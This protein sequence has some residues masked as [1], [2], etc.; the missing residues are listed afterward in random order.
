[1][2]FVKSSHFLFVLIVVFIVLGAAAFFGALKDACAPSALAQD[3]VPGPYVVRSSSATFTLAADASQYVSFPFPTSPRKR[4][5]VG[6]IVA[7]DV[8]PHVVG[9]FSVWV[10]ITGTTLGSFNITAKPIGPGGAV[11]ANVSTTLASGLSPTSG[12]WYAYDYNPI[13]AYG[14]RIDVSQ[15]GGGNAQVEVRQLYQ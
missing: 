8:F 9:Y 3:E 15:T 11:P 12:S 7:P 5:A 4:P 1:M 6:E 2:K 13:V 10:K 14:I